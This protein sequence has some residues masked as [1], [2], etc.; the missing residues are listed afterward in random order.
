MKNQKQ[1]SH[2]ATTQDRSLFEAKR[3]SERTGKGYSNDTGNLYSLALS[4]CSGYS[5]RSGS[6]K[7]DDGHE[8]DRDRDSIADQT[9][10]FLDAPYK[11]FSK[12]PPKSQKCDINDQ[13]SRGSNL[14]NEGEICDEELEMTISKGS[15]FVMRID[16]CQEI[17]DYKTK[18]TLDFPLV[19][20]N[21]EKYQCIERYD[22]VN[23]AQRS[24]KN[25]IRCRII[26]KFIT[27]PWDAVILKAGTRIITLGGTAS[28]GEKLCAVGHLIFYLEEHHPDIK[29][30]THGGDRRGHDFQSQRGVNQTEFLEKEFKRDRKTINGYITKTQYLDRKTLLLIARKK[31]SKSIMERLQQRKNERVKKLI[32]SGTSEK[33]IIPETEKLITDQITKEYP[34][35][36][37]EE[38]Q[39][40]SS[41]RSGRRTSKP[42]PKQ[43][44]F[45]DWQ[46]EQE[47]AELEDGCTED[48]CR[49]DTR[50]V[51]ARLKE[52][53]DGDFEALCDALEAETQK[54]ADIILRTNAVCTMRK[55]GDES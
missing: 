5:D 12:R 47:L 7:L 31:V 9:P 25:T 3:T 50:N 42:K 8:L 4:G 23:A 32:P 22:L 18:S 19:L 33:D 11:E 38:L 14:K 13:D 20:K 16:D 44:R 34:D 15:V 21:G 54:L 41:H 53:A 55:K 36:L 27:M 49:T 39:R 28:Y 35:W 52:A 51:S 45:R 2:P 40:P 1:P 24:G 43:N 30:N 17:P 29:R 37:K 10:P 6:K 46:P 48:S 26:E